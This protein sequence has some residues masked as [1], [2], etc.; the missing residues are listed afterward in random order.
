[1]PRNVKQN[2]ADEVNNWETS[3]ARVKWLVQKRFDGN[4][5]AFAQATAVSHTA[6]NKVVKGQEPGRK[7]LQAIASH[8]GVNEAWLLTGRGQ[9]FAKSKPNTRVPITQTLLDGVPGE[10]P[11]L[12][13]GESIDDGG[14]LFTSTQY[15]L[16]LTSTTPIVRDPSHGF[17]AGDMLLMETNRTKF[18]RE[19]RLGN[20]L[21]VVKRLDGAS[22]SLELGV[23]E[24]HAASIDD[25]PERIEFDGFSQRSKP[26]TKIKEVVYRHHPN[27]SIENFEQMLE[28]DKSQGRLRAARDR[29]DIELPLPKIRYADIVAVWLQLIRRSAGIPI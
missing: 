25:G 15:W 7:L 4:R 24:Y 27:G 28:F 1:M 19:R 9:P 2:A 16:C 22:H 29:Y 14:S 11:E 3:A 12:L 17:R 20:H 5:S 26:S 18:P 6:I 21:C 10:H 23:V 13:T 8:L